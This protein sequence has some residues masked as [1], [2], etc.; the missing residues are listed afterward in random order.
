M[1]RPRAELYE[2]GPTK[3]CLDKRLR[4]LPHYIA[5]FLGVLSSL[6]GSSVYLV[7]HVSVLQ[8]MGQ[9]ISVIVGSNLQPLCDQVSS[10]FRSMPD[11]CIAGVATDETG[12][13]HLARL[14]RPTVAIL[15]LS[16]PRAALCKLISTLAAD[17]VS[18]LVVSDAI[19]E[20]EA[21]DL[22]QCGLSG[23]VPAAV[24]GEM[25][26][27]SVRAIASGEIWIR[28]QVIRKLVDQIRGFSIESCDFHPI[29]REKSLA[30]PLKAPPTVPSAA[31]H[32]KNQFSLTQRELQ[33][34]QAIT[35]GMTNKEVASAFGI[36]EFTVKHHL[37]K[38]FDK[39]G[40]F[41]RLELATFAA[42]HQLCKQ[43]NPQLVT[44]VSAG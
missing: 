22:L 6:S 4:V 23:I 18:P 20:T 24:T 31:N 35:E 21:V 39:M 42:Y 30:Y 33:V 27:Q 3:W 37:A 13:R 41:S 43:P 29:F 17:R 2:G 7:L 11:L 15:N 40:V 10:S 28:R 26:C 12:V 5:D 36:S 32:P 38:I 14:Y 44:S 34:V 1:G 9:R 8:C 19:D 16:V 25:L